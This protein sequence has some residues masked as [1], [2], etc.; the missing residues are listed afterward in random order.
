VPGGFIFP[1]VLTIASKSLALEHWVHLIISFTLSGLIAATYSMYFVQWITLCVTYP[2][3]WYDRQG[4]RATAAAELRNVPKTLWL[5]QV[6]AGL[7]PSFAAI[8]M[9]GMLS[10]GSDDPLFRF[11]VIGLM[12]LG[13]AGFP[14]ATYMTGLLAKAHAALIGL[15]EEGASRGRV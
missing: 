15:G 4:F 14:L 8:L 5:L 9:F 1:T 13:S 12:I 11:L 7:I 10:A 3:L 2:R 6:M